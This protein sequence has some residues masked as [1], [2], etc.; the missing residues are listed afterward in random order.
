MS[1][2]TAPFRRL[3]ENNPNAAGF[4][5]KDIK[6]AWGKLIK[7]AKIRDF[8]F[9]DLRHDFASRLVMNGIEIDLN[10]VHDP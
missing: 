4:Q 1:C 6:T 8:R 5:I 7:D 10:S 9:H 3:G 2:S